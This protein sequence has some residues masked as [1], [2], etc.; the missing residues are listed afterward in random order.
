VINGKS[1][2]AHVTH[3]GDSE[4]DVELPNPYQQQELNDIICTEEINDF[5]I[6]LLHNKVNNYILKKF[7][8]KIA[9]LAAFE[10]Y[11]YKYILRNELEP[12]RNYINNLSIENEPY[13][14]GTLLLKSPLIGPLANFEYVISCIENDDYSIPFFL[15]DHYAVF[16]PP[17]LNKKNQEFYSYGLENYSKFHLKYRFEEQN[18]VNIDIFLEK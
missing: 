14:F 8:A 12:F 10:K 2:V 13:N 6:E 11:G 17:L 9:Y 15:G 4:F 7:Y 1:F 5:H 16:L 3:T 18:I